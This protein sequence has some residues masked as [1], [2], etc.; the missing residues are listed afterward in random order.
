MTSPWSLVENGI[1]LEELIQ[2]ETY[3][4]KVNPSIVPIGY[5]MIFVVSQDFKSCAIAY[6]RDK[7]Y[8]EDFRF[9][10]FYIESDMEVKN[11]ETGKL[12]YIYA[13]IVCPN[14]PDIMYINKFKT[15]TVCIDTHVDAEYILTYRYINPVYVEIGD[16]IGDYNKRIINIKYFE[17]TD[18]YWFYCESDYNECMVYR[19]NRLILIMRLE[20][21]G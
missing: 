10:S 1:I 21:G 14:F 19:S 7:S 18:E 8:I 11:N 4:T 5:N 6:R 17:D 20:L 2:F 3:L 13:M 9:N 15:Y 12:Y 16:R